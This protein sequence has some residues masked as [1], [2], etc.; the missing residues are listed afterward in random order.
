[1]VTLNLASHLEVYYLLG[2]QNS[3]PYLRYDPWVLEKWKK[4][5]SNILCT[6]FWE[7]AGMKT[8]CELPWGKLHAIHHRVVEWVNLGCKVWPM[9]MMSRSNGYS[10]FT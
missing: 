7:Q 8:V 5:D 3:E 9:C 6:C 1:L 4:S 2:T 10:L